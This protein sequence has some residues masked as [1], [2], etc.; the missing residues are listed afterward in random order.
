MMV[1]HACSVRR[2]FRGDETEATDVT[3]PVSFK[4]RQIWLCVPAELKHL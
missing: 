4:V 3:Y 2:L 1:G